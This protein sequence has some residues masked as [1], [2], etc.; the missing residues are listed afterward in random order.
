M[1]SRLFY[2]FVHVLHAGTEASYACLPILAT[3]PLHLSG[4]MKNG[5]YVSKN[6]KEDFMHNS[7]RDLLA[8]GFCR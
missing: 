7:D 6:L 3:S 4:Y 8:D 5:L 2:G 1:S